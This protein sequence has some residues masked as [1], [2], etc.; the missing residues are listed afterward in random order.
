MGIDSV[1]GQDASVLNGYIVDSELN[2]C[3]NFGGRMVM[4]SGSA[5][6]DPDQTFEVGDQV[7]KFTVAAGGSPGW[8]C[9][10]AGIGGVAVFKAMANL[11]A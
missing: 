7:W 6:T 8:V 4:R 3:A 9:T 2:Q 10:T 1:D 5:P 11:A